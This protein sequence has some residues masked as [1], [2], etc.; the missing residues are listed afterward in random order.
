MSD[1]IIDVREAFGQA[2]ALLLELGRTNAD[3]E[4]ANRYLELEVA[5]LRERWQAKIAPLEEAR[6][7]LEN[8]VRVVA[9][10][11]RDRFFSGDSDRL[12]LP[13]G[14]LLYEV[15]RRVKRARG[16]LER[17]EAAGFLEA[18]KVAKSV[19]WDAL[20]AWPEERLIYVGTE[21]I[22]K[23]VYAYE[24]KGSGQ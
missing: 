14:A 16:V 6:N 12:E 7:R 18:V 4:A 1:Q 3:L 9:K 24:L 10:T 5:A 8:Q 2:D 17:L 15:Q 19:D 22:K 13:H 11:N 20:E 21:R 23:E